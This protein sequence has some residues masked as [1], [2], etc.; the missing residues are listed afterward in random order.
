M[1]KIQFPDSE[2]IEFLQRLFYTLSICPVQMNAAYDAPDGKSCLFLDSEHDIQDA[3]MGTPHYQGKA[4][5]FLQKQTHFIVKRIRLFHLAASELLRNL[6]KGTASVETG[7]QPSGVVQNKKAFT[8][9]V[10]DAPV[11]QV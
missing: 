11:R 4:V 7:H 8:H 5:F 9:T 1:A 3:P 2:V 10:S 6:L